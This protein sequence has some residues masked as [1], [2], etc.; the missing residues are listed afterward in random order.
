M[1][2]KSPPVAA[3]VSPAIRVAPPEE[4]ARGV[5]I[6]GFPGF[7]AGRLVE[8][9]IARHGAGAR[10]FLLAESR[11]VLAAADRCRQLEARFPG[12][13]WQVVEGDIRRPDLGLAPA[14]RAALAESV[15]EVWHLAAVYD[16]AVAPSFAY[17]VNVDGT[18]HVLDLCEQLP[19]LEKLN[20]ISTCFVAGDR[21]GRIYEDELDRGQGFKNHYESTKH[22]AEK[23]VRRRMSGIPTSVF[24]PSIVVGDSETGETAKAD[25]PYY[26]MGLL[27]RLPKR[28]PMVHLGASLAKVNLVPVDFVVDAMDRIAADPRSTGKTFALAD[29]DPLR[30]REILPLMCEALGRAPVVGTVP[31]RIAR[32]I[33]LR[34]DVQRAL[35][36]PSEMFDYFSHEAEFDTTNTSSLLDGVR[37]PCPRLPDYLPRLVAYAQA[38]PRLFQVNA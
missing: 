25:G 38:N 30:A 8:K 34:P 24:R 13:R 23:H 7:L 33:V 17:Q 35:R 37:G 21:K 19:H 22:W 3:G 29:P 18:L 1:S 28:M 32:A 11:F 10:F 27:M 9:L 12:F 15:R 20:Y 2:R 4:G 16:L 6:T 36:A 26:V 31:D 5:L 14:A